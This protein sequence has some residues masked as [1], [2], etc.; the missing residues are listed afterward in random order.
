M[1][2]KQNKYILR[3]LLL[4]IGISFMALGIALTTKANLGTPPITSLPY[5][6][7]LGFTPSLGAFTTLLNMAF[8]AMQVLLL[9]KKFPK[10]QFLQI[11]TSLLFGFFIDFWMMLVPV[12]PEGVYMYKLLFVGAG[13]LVLAFGIFVE[14]SAD[15][16]M[17]PGEGAVLVL[18]LVTRRDF[19]ILK[20]AFDS[21]LVFLA[22]MLSFMLFQD[23]RGVREGT[24]LSAV[25]VGL[26]V[27]FFFAVRKRLAAPP[28][29]ERRA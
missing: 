24:I 8:V 25:S 15:V 26:V 21:T 12:P 1:S 14:V 2:A 18:A 6:A 29:G 23:L 28:A 10:M 7:S 17:M 11:P 13:I 20:V 9:G 3:Y 5:V 27:R 22:V 16:V 19:G 4:F